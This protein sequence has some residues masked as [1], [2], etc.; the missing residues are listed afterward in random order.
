[1]DARREKIQK[2]NG[3]VWCGV[4]SR[5]HSV[6]FA[7]DSGTEYEAM[8]LGAMERERERGLSASTTSRLAIAFQ[9]RSHTRAQP[10]VT[11]M[12]L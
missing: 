7:S 2:R 4:V 11:T 1:M 10:A 5:R 8:D 6:T 9:I 3:V 12:K